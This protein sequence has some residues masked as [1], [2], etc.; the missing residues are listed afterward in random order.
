MARRY[1][2]IIF[3]AMVAVVIVLFALLISEYQH[4]QQLENIN[5]HDSLFAAL[6]GHGTL[7]ISQASLVQPWMTFDYINHLFTLP[8]T[9]LQTTLGIKDSRYPRL[10]LHEYAEDAGLNE[11]VFLAKAQNAVRSYTAPQ[12]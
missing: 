11:A 12:P 5:A 1:L 4:I 8:P 2:K 6:H 9:Y 7:S 10:T 3:A